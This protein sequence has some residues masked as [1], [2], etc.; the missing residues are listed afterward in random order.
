MKKK[1]LSVALTICL[2]FACICV[3]ACDQPHTHTWKTTLST[4]DTHH[5]YA[6]ESADCVDVKDMAEHNYTDGVCICGVE[7]PSAQSLSKSELAVAYKS[8]ASQS[9]LAFGAGTVVSVQPMAYTSELPETDLEEKDTPEGIKLAKGDAATMFS[10]I[11]MIGEYYEN[12]DFIITDNVISLPLVA[13]NMSQTPCAGT[14]HLL[15]TLDKDNNNVKLE[16][17]LD[18]PDMNGMSVSAYYN[19][20][21][22]YNFDTNTLISFNLVMVQDYTAD[23]V[24]TT[25]FSHEKMTSSGR[26]YWL[27]HPQSNEY[28][29]IS[30][31][32]REDFKTKMANAVSLQGNFDNEFNN[33]IANSMAAYNGVMNS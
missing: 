23:N 32:I 7:D 17:I 19:F 11:Y 16:M 4:S 12:A 21:I 6:C 5:W 30:L 8:V 10:L 31:Q 9:W 20:D 18:L 26:Y 3:I 27:K 2:V 22:D 15:P 33:Y 13:V 14:M 29:T 24:T 25:Q 28:K 1:I